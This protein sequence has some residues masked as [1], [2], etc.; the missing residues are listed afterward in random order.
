MQQEFQ[1][2]NQITPGYFFI[3]DESPPGDS[4]ETYKEL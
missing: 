4:S 2:M 1:G 3:D